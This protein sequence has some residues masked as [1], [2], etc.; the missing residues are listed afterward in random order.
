MEEARPDRVTLAA[1]G[2]LVVMFGIN[3]NAVKATVNELAPFWSAGIRFAAAAL[4]LIAVLF[5][6]RQEL[7][8]GRA[9]FGAVLFGT[10]SFAAFFGFGYWGIQRLPISVA[11]LIF[12]SV[13][14][15]TFIAAVLHRLEPF[16]WLTLVGALI[17][18]GGIALMAGRIA[19]GSVSILGILALIAAGVSSAEAAVVAKRFPLVPPIVMNAVGM[20]TGAVILLLLS[21]AAGEAHEAPSR[22]ATWLALV[23][24]VLLGSIVAFVMYVFVLRRWTVSGTSYQFVLAPIVAVVFA[25]TFQGE[26]VTGALLAGGVLVLAGVYVGAL[27]HTGKREPK[28]QAAAAATPAAAVTTEEHRPELAGVPADCVR[29]S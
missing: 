12:A 5:L 3:G 19:T 18:V 28:K 24:L 10:F 9:L 7:P 23:Y 20:T 13:P 2:A 25:A 29:C 26:R 22:P 14:L 17:V 8:R 15:I 4:I 11:A 16:R 21:F 27:L 6:R 1:F